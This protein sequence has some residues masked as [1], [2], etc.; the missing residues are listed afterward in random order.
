MRKEA[1]EWFKERWDK[2]DSMSL[3][4]FIVSHFDVVIEH[5]QTII[6]DLEDQKENLLKE[7]KTNKELS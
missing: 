1:L 4:D 3:G 7:M 2:K 6:A 5:H